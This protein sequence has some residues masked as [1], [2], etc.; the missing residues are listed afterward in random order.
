MTLLYVEAHVWTYACVTNPTSSPSCSW[1]WLCYWSRDM[2]NFDFLE[3][4]LGIVS[5]AHF[6]YDFSKIC[7]CYVLLTDQISF[8]GFLYFLR[9]WQYVYC[10]CILSRLWRHGFWN[11][12]YRSSRAVFSTCPKSHDKNLKVH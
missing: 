2:L 3:K 9:D 1:W 8:S 10:N 12:P 4:D 6:V 11:W 7:F 5:P